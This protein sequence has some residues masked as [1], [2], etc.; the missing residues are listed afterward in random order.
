MGRGV[1]CTNMHLDLMMQQINIHRPDA[2]LFKYPYI[3]SWEDVSR[4]Q[5][6]GASGSGG[7]AYYDEEE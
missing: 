3:P 6:G 2:Y 5:Q 7:G 1:N 4:E